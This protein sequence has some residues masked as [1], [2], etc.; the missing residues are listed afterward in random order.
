MPI[1]EDVT[2]RIPKA[3]MTADQRFAGRRPDV[4]VYQT[5][6]L[7]EAITLAGPIL[8]RLWVSTSGTASDW[9]VKL[10]DVLPDD[11]P[12]HDDLPPG[13]HLGGY[14]MMVRSEV[15]RG[16]YRNSYEYPEPFVAH[17]PTEVGLPRLFG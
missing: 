5:E 14:Q 9:I 10:I 4:L 12:G 7:D 15:I 8:A 1:T 17:K 2:T 11:T 6:V 13:R 16:R 3:Y